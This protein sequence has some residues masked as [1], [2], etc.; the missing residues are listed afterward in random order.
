MAAFA[1]NKAAAKVSGPANDAATDDSP[2]E[3]HQRIRARPARAEASPL[4]AP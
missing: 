1:M 4:D 2:R 3:L